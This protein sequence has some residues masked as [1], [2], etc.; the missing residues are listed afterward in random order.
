MKPLDSTRKSY[1]HPVYCIGFAGRTP[2]ILLSLVARYDIGELVDLRSES[3]S[4]APGPFQRPELEAAL[5]AAKV[6]FRRLAEFRP[7][8]DF[9]FSRYQARAAR[10]TSRALADRARSHPLGL[11]GP[12][13]APDA[14]FGATT[15][16]L[17]L[18]R[19]G[20]TVWNVRPDSTLAAVDLLTVQS[21]QK[22]RASG[23][24]VLKFTVAA[25]TLAMLLGLCTDYRGA[26]PPLPLSS[27]SSDAWY[28]SDIDPDVFYDRQGV[29]HRCDRD[30]NCTPI[31]PEEQRDDSD[32]AERLSYDA[33]NHYDA[34][35]KEGQAFSSGQG[36]PRT[37][38]GTPRGG[39]GATASAHSGG[40]FSGSGHASVGGGHASGGS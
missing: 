2:K 21:R 15:L 28:A 37:V 17:E 27:P 23:K 4:M 33:M 16:A 9:Y 7:S 25:T 14:E 26:P 39:F 36:S 32:P 18:L 6:P 8:D 19:A 20:V 12:G 35:R 11:I 30:G 22:R 5:Q 40:A 38:T 3:G 24:I 13:E 31:A 29:P 34:L 1:A 10:T